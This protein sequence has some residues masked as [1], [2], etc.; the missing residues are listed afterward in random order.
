MFM[1]ST[2]V[3]WTYALAPDVEVRAA[4]DGALLRTVTT[5]MWL[6]AAAGEFEML[7]VLAGSGGSEAQFQS[8]VRPSDS[9]R[10]VETCCSAHRLLAEDPPYALVAERQQSI[11]QQGLMPPKSAQLSEFLFRTLHQREGRRPYP[12]GG[13]CYPLNAYV[14]VHRCL[15]IASGLYAYGPASHELITVGEPGSGFE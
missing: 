13:A 6:E 5:E 4:T 14:A 3:P 2:A 8:R 9:D 15:G 1:T 11:W 12:S 10:T 7:E